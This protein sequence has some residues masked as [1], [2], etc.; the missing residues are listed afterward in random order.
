M[1]MVEIRQKA[2]ELGIKPGKTRKADLIRMVQVEEGNDVCFQTE[3]NNCV[4]YDCCWLDDC[5]QQ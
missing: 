1:K 3:K 5:L 4:Q 2:N